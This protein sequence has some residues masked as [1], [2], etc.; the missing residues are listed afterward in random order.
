M[1]SLSDFGFQNHLANPPGTRFAAIAFSAVLLLNATKAL[2][3][4]EHEENSGDAARVMALETLWNQAEVDGDVRALSQIVPETF[5]YVDI[6]GSLRTKA[7]FLE[8]MK[9]TPEKPSELRNESMIAH[10]YSNT[11]L[12]TGVYR[13]KGTVRGKRYSRRGRFTDTWIKVNSA[14]LCVA[15]QSTLIEK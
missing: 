1:R 4:Q 12:V 2:T 6:D 9:N 15:S 3:A 8:L 7:E 10:A 11:V 14:W 13:E 5:I